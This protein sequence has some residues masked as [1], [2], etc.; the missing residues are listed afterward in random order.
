MQDVSVIEFS[1]S[2]QASYE[3]NHAGWWWTLKWKQKNTKNLGFGPEQFDFRISFVQIEK[4]LSQQNRATQFGRRA[5]AEA[6]F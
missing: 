5:W 3:V 4:F 2:Q 1:W 6:N